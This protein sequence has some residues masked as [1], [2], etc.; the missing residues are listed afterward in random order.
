MALA[1]PSVIAAAVV[2]L[3]AFVVL[4]DGWRV[5]QGRSQVGRLGRLSGGGFAWQADAGRELVRNGSQLVTLGV[6]M[7]LPWILFERSGT[8]IWWLLLFDG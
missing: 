3:V 8:P 1:S 6:M 2:A 7:A 4:Y 5:T